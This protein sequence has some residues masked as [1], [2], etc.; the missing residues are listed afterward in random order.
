M[1]AKEA[2]WA[3]M[4]NSFEKFCSKGKKRAEFALRS[5]QPFRSFEKEI[6]FRTSALQMALIFP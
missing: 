2:D 1:G 6:G 4:L 5:L 3:G